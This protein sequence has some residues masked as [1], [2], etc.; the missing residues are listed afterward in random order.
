MIGTGGGY[1]ESLLVHLC[2]GN[3][4][5]IDSCIN[6][7]D[8]S[9]LPL[10]YLKKI[11]VDIKSQVKL[12]LCTHWHE[13][14][15]LGLS[16]ILK[17]CENA[18]FS[19]SRVNDIKKFLQFVSLDYLKLNTN[20]SNCSTEEFN[21]CLEIIESVKYASI[22]RPL[23]SESI[24][25]INLQ[26]IAL[27]P[28]DYSSTIFDQEI[29]TLITK[30][31]SQNKK[32]LKET[33]NFR[34]VALQLKLGDRRALLGADLEVGTDNRLGWLNILNHSITLDQK[35]TYFKI[36]HHGSENGYHLDIWTDLLEE[37]P[38]STI[39]PWNRNTKLPDPEMLLTYT[40][41]TEFLYITSPVLNSSRPKRRSRQLEKFIKKSKRKLM[42]VKFS[43]GIIRSRID[44]TNPIDK[45]SV[46]NYGEAYHVNPLIT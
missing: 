31:G 39:T 6:P 20:I 14:H 1:G 9:N 36:P 8:K 46:S 13:D 18:I 21:K 10:E 44:L 25:N 35:S 7:F 32:C 17:E 45:W 40:N 22:D 12:V 34:S 11:G 29:S 15:I 26:V 23:Y 37:T 33:P 4:L 27:S 41:H 3:W 28:S 43:E 2:D 16:E 38:T 19:M 24:D 30:Y 5:V 42:E